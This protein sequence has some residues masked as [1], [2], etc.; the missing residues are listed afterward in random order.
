MLYTEIGQMY[1][2][3]Q[4]WDPLRVCVVG[5]SYSP[6]FY[7]Y[8]ENSKVRDVFYQIAEETEEDYQK[9]IQILQSFGVRVIRPTISDNYHDYLLSGNNKILPP[10]MTPR[11]HCAMIGNKFY[12]SNQYNKINTKTIWNKISGS[13]WPSCP[14]TPHEFNQLP[15]DIKKELQH[16]FNIS[17]FNDLLYNN[18][19]EDLVNDLEAHNNVIDYSTNINSAQVT[20]IGKDLYFGT[21]EGSVFDKK[22]ANS[23]IP[24]LSDYRCHVVDMEGHA[25]G[26]F[27]PVKPGL[28]VSLRDIPTY[29]DT[30]PD[31]EVVYLPYQSWDQVRPFLDLKSKNKGKWWVPGHELNDEFTQYVETWMSNWVGYVE[32]TVFDVNMLVINENNVICNNYNEQVFRAFERHNIT[33]HVVNF[34]HRYFWDGG[35]HCIT[36]D[37]H[38]E[39]NQKDYFP[40]RD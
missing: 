7:N 25:D 14:E 20:R 17:I 13:T 21:V 6:N 1:S 9:L 34:R 35:L 27:C 10:P 12:L 31:W 36:A 4:H 26:T 37:I 39:G 5:R 16:H 24:S 38:R 22:Y 29:K 2:V 23:L 28:I 11:D 18:C 8:I 33:P 19:Y 30:F 32:E 40:W 15:N 3:H